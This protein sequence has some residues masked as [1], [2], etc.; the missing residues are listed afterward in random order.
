M[1]A[2]DEQFHDLYRQLRIADQL[3]FYEARHAEYRRAHRQAAAIRNTLLILAAV[4]GVVAVFFSDLG[5]AELGAAA[6]V[7]GA[8]AAAVT[9][10]E[11]LMGF[12]QF[13]SLYH[14]A[15]VSL[16]YAL[17]DWDHAN[18]TDDLAAQVR[19]VEEVFRQEKEQVFGRWGEALIRPPHVPP[20]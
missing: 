2:R 3:A 4:A 16:K 13:S 17:F 5:R 9:A 15:A 6:A 14:N 10:Y 20:P 19:L 18:T 7:F 12:P 8:L 1:S 11:A